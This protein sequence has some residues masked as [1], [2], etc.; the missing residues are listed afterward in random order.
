MASVINATMDALPE[1]VTTEFPI[2]RLTVA[3]YHAMIEA[4]IIT[5][6]DRVELLEGWL[7]EKLGKNPPHTYLRE[8]LEDWLKDAKPAGWIVHSQEPVTMID[9]EPEPDVMLVRGTRDDFL[10]RHP[11][12]DEI[13]LVIEVS[14]S[15]IRVDRRFKQRLYAQAKIPA[16]WIA[17]VSER[18]FEVYTDIVVDG[19]SVFYRQ[20]TIYTA[21][22]TLPLILDG[23]EIARIAVSDLLAKL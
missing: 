5:P 8:Q 14:D 4:G 18:V 12:P 7:V 22:D 20:R 15:T 13:G 16:Y 21:K 19:E 1:P 6:D 23:K 17:N 2:Q 3:K 10:E 11:R 9:S